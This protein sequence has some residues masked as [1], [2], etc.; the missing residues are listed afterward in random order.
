LRN[1]PLA[2]LLKGVDVSGLMG[3][4]PEFLNG[5]LGNNAKPTATPTATPKETSQPV[6]TKPVDA[7]FEKILNDLAELAPQVDK[8]ILEEV[9]KTNGF[10]NAQD[11]Y[12]FLFN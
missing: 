6:F 10:K 7:E 3:M 12:N 2:N 1:H 4:V 11:A 8:S 5:F 9:I